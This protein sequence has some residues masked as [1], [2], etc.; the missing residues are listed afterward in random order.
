MNKTIKRFELD[1]EQIETSRASGG[2]IYTIPE[3]IWEKD[4]WIAEQ[5]L[6]GT[7]L[8]MHITPEGN[9]FD[10]RRISDKTQ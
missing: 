7:R 2:A 8:K 10:T 1:L 3:D 4:G 5:K 9:R 6:D